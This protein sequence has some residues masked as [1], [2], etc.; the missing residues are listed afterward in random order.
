[1]N[2]TQPFIPGLELSELFYREAVWPILSSCGYASLAHSAGLLDS[3]SEVFGFDTPMS[4]DHHW[5]PRVLIFL[6]ADDHAQLSNE[7]RKLL[8]HE[9]PFEFK[10]YP[11]NFGPPDDIGVQLLQRVQ[12]RPINHRVEFFTIASF[13]RKWLNGYDPTAGEPSAEQWGSFPQQALFAIRKGSLFR[14]DLGIEKVRESLSFYPKWLWLEKL[15]QEWSAIGEEEAFVGR[16]GDLGDELGSRLIACRIVDHLMRIVFLLE[17]EYFPYSKWFGTAFS[18][19][20][21]APTLTPLLQ[22][23]IRADKWKE[24]EHFL[25]KIYIEVMELQYTVDEILKI[26]PKVSNFYDRPF[27]VPHAEEIAQVIRQRQKGPT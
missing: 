25:S 4:T 9:L 8:S 10:G 13:F 23:V 22:G 12:V 15:A 21:P 26:E 6:Q 17:K 19:L 5:G 24:R 16:C 20:T 18:K 2:Q 7:L 3:G 27:L 1:M 14:D 11:T